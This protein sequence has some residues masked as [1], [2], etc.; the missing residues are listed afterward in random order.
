[1][2]AGQ[3]ERESLIISGIPKN[4]EEIKTRGVVFRHYVGK[5]MPII[6]Q[7]KQL[8][9]GITPY[10]VLKLGFGKEVY[11]DLVG[12]FLTTPQTPPQEVGLPASADDYI[13]LEVYSGTPVVKIEKAI[14]LIPGRA[15]APEWLKTLYLEYK[16][17]GKAN[18]HYKDTFDK[19]DRR[20]GVDPTFMK[21]KIKSYRFQ[22][23]TV[24][25]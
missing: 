6:L 18:P 11:E 19:F 8:K 9:T 20:G 5:A 10:V 23:K 21:I 7:T 2:Y 25:L 22:G 15:D 16:K 1:M 14:F 3:P 12:I 24:V 4:I 13:D 17:T